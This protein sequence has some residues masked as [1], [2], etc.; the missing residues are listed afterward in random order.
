MNRRDVDPGQLHGGAL[1][2]WYRR[3]PEEIEEE[4]RL[5]SKQAYEE[6]FG[7]SAPPPRRPS[8]DERDL[9][10]IEDADG[11]IRG[12]DLVEADA[13]IPGLAS[14]GDKQP[15][16][17]QEARVA[18]PRMRVTDVLPPVRQGATQGRTPIGPAVEGL[19]QAPGAP[20]SFFADSAVFGGDY[21]NPS[22]PSPLDRVQPVGRDRYLLNDG[23]SIVS[24]DEVERI[25]AEQQRRTKGEEFAPSPYANAVDRLADG[26]IP[27]ASQLEKG[28]W[29]RDPTCHPYGGWE[30]DAGWSYYPKRTQ[31]Y[32]QQV[33]GARG[34][35]YVVRSPGKRPVKFDGCGIDD[36]RRPLK[37][38]KGPGYEGLLA[39]AI[40]ST[41]GHF[42]IGGLAGQA[43]RQRNVAGKSPIDWSVAE[44]PVADQF[45]D[46]EVRFHG[47][48]IRHVP[49]RQ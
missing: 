2:D 20:G 45:K 22:W 34:V 28:K 49:A 48:N 16:S 44:K 46:D 11:R 43:E 32:E 38:A 9:V 30:I 25:H 3:T 35:D 5:R 27:L 31:D 21:F 26:Q 39:R 8:V 29:E 47:L 24:A 15:D 33:T 19:P 37:E 41:F 1:D 4:R 36:P 7:G 14:G 18:Q 10:W 42:V 23:K 12:V 40:R 17:W 13:A 6:F